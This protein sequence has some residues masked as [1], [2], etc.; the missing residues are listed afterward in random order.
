MA[1]ETLKDQLT[2]VVAEQTKSVITML[3]VEQ[4]AALEAK[5]LALPIEVRSAMASK[6][7]NLN[8]V[9]AYIVRQ[10]VREANGRL[11]SQK[12]PVWYSILKTNSD[13]LRSQNKDVAG[14]AEAQLRN[15][16]EEIDTKES[17]N[18]L[19]KYKVAQDTNSK[20]AH[21]VK[22]CGIFGVSPANL[23]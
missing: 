3:T 16:A 18:L 19:K 6:Y 5:L 9:E 20:D 11:A 15:L 10:M 21:I 8:N 17:I 2:A 23:A 22:L 13:S 12:R 14:W 4:Q 7:P 1:Q